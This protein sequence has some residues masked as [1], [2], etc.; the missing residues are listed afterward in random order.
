[1]CQCE[2]QRWMVRP[3]ARPRHE[4]LGANSLG[5]RAGDSRPRVPKRKCESRARPYMTGRNVG[6]P[7]EVQ[8]EV[9]P[10]AEWSDAVPTA[11]G[12]ASR[13]GRKCAW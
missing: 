11:Q 4:R 3:A 12:R 10:A 5:R 6:N 1:M 2:T 7:T 9:R 13:G 8:A